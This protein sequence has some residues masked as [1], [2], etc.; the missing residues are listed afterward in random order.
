MNSFTR[1]LK[2]GIPI[3]LGYLS[4]SFTF[5]IMAV[6]YGF[7]WWQAVLISMTTLTSAGQLAGIGVM[8]SP[9]QYIEMLISQ[10]TINVRYSFMSVSLSQKAEP[11]FRG[12]KRWLLGFFM[13]DE[14]FAVA[15]AEKEVST[16]FFLGLSVAPYIGWTLGTLL[17]S[18]LGNILPALVMNALCLA[19]YGMFLAIVA[20]DARKS[21]AI[22]AVVAVA[23]LLHG[24]FYYLPVLSEIPSG[25]SV[26]ICAVAAAVFGS[27]VFPIKDESGEEASE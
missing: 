5:G 4:V 25:L 21:R 20:P 22:L 8:I 23:A 26:S 11:A 1:G 24:L 17:G 14:I 3:G 16:K 15:S 13:T 12:I 18:V 10:L 19:I 9:G 2:S 7:D 6:S 27:I